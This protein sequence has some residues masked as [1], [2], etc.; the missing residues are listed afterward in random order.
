MLTATATCPDGKVLLGG[1]ADITADIEEQRYRIHLISSYPSSTNEWTAV[2]GVNSG[3]GGGDVTVQAFVLCSP[4]ATAEATPVPT[5]S[6]TPTPIPTPTPTP[7]QAE[8]LQIVINCAPA[9]QGT[10]DEIASRWRPDFPDPPWL[11]GEAWEVDGYIS[12]RVT[13]PY[14]DNIATWQRGTG[15]DEGQ[16]FSIPQTLARAATDW[17][18]LTFWDPHPFQWLQ[19]P[20]LYSKLCALEG[21]GYP[22]R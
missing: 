14:Y 6:P 2:A 16:Y 11:F 17:P 22:W 15:P 4:T 13:T 10:K 21:Q 5:P 12:A 8:P 7:T 3:V 18:P 19:Y 20:G 9:S 1:G